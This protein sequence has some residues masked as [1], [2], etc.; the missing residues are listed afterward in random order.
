[1]FK[2]KLQI[3]IKDEKDL[4]MQMK[5]SQLKDI[6]MSG[7]AIKNTISYQVIE[8]QIAVYAFKIRVAEAFQKLL[9]NLDERKSNG[10]SNK[11]GT[12]EKS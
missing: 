5:I 9:I 4:L 2:D 1:M 7:R 8:L 6:A 11:K 10:G 12:E 3:F